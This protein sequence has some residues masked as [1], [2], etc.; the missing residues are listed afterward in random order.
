VECC[1]NGGALI[2]EGPSAGHRNWISQGVIATGVGATRAEV[3]FA[4]VDGVCF[5]PHEVLYSPMLTIAQDRRDDY[6]TIARTGS[7]AVKMWKN[8]E[9]PADPAAG[10]NGGK[11]VW[12]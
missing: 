12:Y 4:D 5:T 3:V 10:P 6:L 7:G 11:V 1:L 8:L 9:E 2:D